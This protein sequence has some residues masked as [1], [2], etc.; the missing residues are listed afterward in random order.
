MPVKRFSTFLSFCTFLITTALGQ[1]S[2][3]RLKT[4]PFRFDTNQDEASFHPTMEQKALKLTDKTFAILSKTSSS[5]FSIESYNDNLTRLW[6]TPISLGL[7]EVPEVFN[8]SDKY[9][10]LLTY[11]MVKTEGAQR[12]YA[13]YFD[14]KTGTRIGQ[15]TLMSAPSKGRKIGIT[16]SENGSVVMVYQHITPN[17][18]IS[19]TRAF[20]YNSEFK[21]IKEQVYEFDDLNVSFDPMPRVDNDGN[22]YLA[23]ITDD[24]RKIRIRKFTPRTDVYG[25]LTQIIGGVFDGTDIY[26]FDHLL[27]LDSSG[28]VYFAAIT[29]EDSTMLYYS[30]KVTRFDFDKYEVH[31]PEEFKFSQR[32]LDSMPYY[33][34]APGQK[35]GS[36]VDTYLSDLIITP[37]NDI[38][39]IAEK[40]YTMDEFHGGH[41][42]KEMLLFRYNEFM[43]YEWLI[44]IDKDQFASHYQF[45]SGL[46][47]KSAYYPENVQLVTFEKINN[48]T[49]V[50]LRTVSRVN[51]TYRPAEALNIISPYDQ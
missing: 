11:K 10:Y 7:D 43:G 41:V 21:Q 23:F 40:R 16:C 34:P 46:G 51:G 1:S 13:Y 33:K 47:F 6:S 8:V 50:Y 28:K 17:R 38:I 45:Y 31:M 12:I 32:Y 24:Y 39:M 26:I 37:E 35:R 25:E 4:I 27:K 19:G 49:D 9:V 20:V 42:G 22:Q 5:N 30:L 18:V 29:V 14:K 15:K 36:I 44:N 48:R 2:T 3:D